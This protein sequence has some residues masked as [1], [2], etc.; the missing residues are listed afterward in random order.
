M[1]GSLCN[2]VHEI[3]V[4]T[5]PGSVKCAIGTK[6]RVKLLQSVTGI[7]VVPTVP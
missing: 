7:S 5:V 4:H 6:G 2:T 1:I 3:N